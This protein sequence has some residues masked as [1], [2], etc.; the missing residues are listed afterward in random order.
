MENPKHYEAQAEKAADDV[1]P[2]PYQSM[3]YGTN[4]SPPS[5]PAP[6]YHG[7]E[8]STAAGPISGGNSKFPPALNAYYKWG[9]TKTFYLG[10]TKDTPRLAGRWHSGLSKKPELELFDGPDDKGALLATARHGSIFRSASVLTIPAR[11]GVPHDTESQQIS[12]SCPKLLKDKTYAFAADVGVG[13]ET[14]REEFEWRSSHGSEV[15]EVGGLRWGWKLVRLSGGSVGGG[16]DRATRELGSTSDGLEVVAAWAHNSSAS[17]TKAFKFQLMGSALTGML[18]DR[19]A[20]VALVSALWL[21]AIE[22]ATAST[23]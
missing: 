18:G 22:V 4:T 23:A 13:K 14:R 19:G 5:E 11:E 21:W 6:S 9:F 12:M 16:G 8:S 1:P 3:G 10:E 2:P 7:G 20:T 15:R 17:M